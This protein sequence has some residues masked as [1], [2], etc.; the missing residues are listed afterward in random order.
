MSTEPQLIS[1]ALPKDRQDEMKRAGSGSEEF[2]ERRA[3]HLLSDTEGMFPVG[4]LEPDEI[5][6]LDTEMTRHGALDWYR[7][8]T[9]GGAR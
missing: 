5:E 4:R 1:M 7:N 2:L 8:P 3:R 6:V 9:G